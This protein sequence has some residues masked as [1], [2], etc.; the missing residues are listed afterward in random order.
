MLLVREL[1]AADQ[2]LLQSKSIVSMTLMLLSMFQI[3]CVEVG[4]VC[5]HG[6]VWITFLLCWLHNSNALFC[7]CFRQL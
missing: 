5:N 7:G 3:S 6:M 1:R 2:Q 4:D